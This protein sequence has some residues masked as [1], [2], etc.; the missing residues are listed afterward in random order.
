MSMHTHLLTLIAVSVADSPANRVGFLMEKSVPSS[1]RRME[2]ITFSSSPRR[3]LANSVAHRAMAITLALAPCTPADGGYRDFDSVWDV[4][5]SRAQGAAAFAAATARGL[6]HAP[7]PSC[8]SDTCVARTVDSQWLATDFADLMPPSR[9]LSFDASPP[10][11]EPTSRSSTIMPLSFENWQSVWFWYRHQG[12]LDGLWD[13][14]REP[15]RTVARSAII[16]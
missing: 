6:V 10:L 4:V 5:L 13:F 8:P 3:P 1:S 11:V 15:P 2:G 9:C 14:E 7:G 16:E 12:A